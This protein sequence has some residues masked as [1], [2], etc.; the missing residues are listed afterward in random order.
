MISTNTVNTIGFNIKCK[1]VRNG[2]ESTVESG[3]TI[4]TDCNLK[5]TIETYGGIIEPVNELSIYWEVSNGGKLDHHEHQEI[6][7][8]GKDESDGL[9]SFSRELVY[10][11][12]HLLRCRVFNKKKK[13]NVTKIF[14]I[15]A[16]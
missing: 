7:Y 15:E 13:Y 12:T 11:G 8:K 2:L 5:F 9:F 10:K 3:D 6:Y 16:I 4:N 14:S 1:L